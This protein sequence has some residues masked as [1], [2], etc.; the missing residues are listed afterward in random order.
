IEL[1]FAD[2]TKKSFTFQE[3][4]NT[5]LLHNQLSAKLDELFEVATNPSSDDENFKISYEELYCFGCDDNNEESNKGDDKANIKGD[6]ESSKESNNEA[7]KEG[8]KKDDENSNKGN[9][10]GNKED[11]NDDSNKDDKEDDK[12]DDNEDSNK[13]DKDKDNDEDDESDEG[14]EGDEDEI[15]L[16]PINPIKI[17]KAVIST[18]LPN[19]E[20]VSKR[21]ANQDLYS[22]LGYF[23]NFQPTKK[24]EILTGNKL[25]VSKQ[26]HELL[27][28]ESE[29]TVIAPFYDK[30]SFIKK[31]D[32]YKSLLNYL[33]ELSIL[34][35][36][37]VVQFN[38]AQINSRLALE[39][40]NLV[41]SN[42]DDI[43]N[44]QDQI[45]L[46]ST[47]Y[48]FIFDCNITTYNIEV[49]HRIL[50][51]FL[52]KFEIAYNYLIEWIN[53]YTTREKG[54]NISTRTRHRKQEKNLQNS[55][56]VSNNI[57][58]NSLNNQI[59]IVSIGDIEEIIEQRIGR[60]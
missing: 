22:Y 10:E 32:Y 9:K 13:G 34:C 5:S 60:R 3:I 59:N 43:L 26:Y 25:K 38:P 58:N 44:L 50:L 57:S 27:A 41:L 42:S 28:F 47:C 2:K 52:Y 20:R 17:R 37:S 33:K 6:N 31:D 53:K 8:D 45:M 29:L 18:K 14:D 4:S 39:Y 54:T 19:F 51:Q 16:E 35:K 11:N 40:E 12:E 23:S 1:I 36:T 48:Q 21:Q 24:K 49:S 30:N 46:L 7:N 15:V 55:F 56:L